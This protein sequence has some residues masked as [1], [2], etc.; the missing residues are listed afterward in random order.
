MQPHPPTRKAPSA[1]ASARPAQ[2]SVPEPAPAPCGRR[3][4]LGALGEELACEH[5]SGE[6]LVILARN[7]R[8]RDGEIDI[9]ARDGC[10]LA[11]VEVKARRLPAA[12]DRARHVAA[13][14]YAQAVLGWPSRRQRVRLRRLALA[15]L[16]DRERPAP[17]A[18]ELRFDVVRVLLDRRGRPLQIEHLK[19]VA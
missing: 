19:G 2:A 5:L 9:V 17:H 11:F 13:D 15:W 6:G 16:R 7:Q 3:R 12:A 4:Q 18:R 14:A 10:A 8:S 1:P